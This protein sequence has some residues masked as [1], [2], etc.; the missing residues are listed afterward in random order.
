MSKGRIHHCHF[1]SST[2]P[3][4]TAVRLQQLCPR[5]LWSNGW[6]RIQPIPRLSFNVPCFLGYYIAVNRSPFHTSDYYTL[7]T[8]SMSLPTPSTI[9]P[10]LLFT[11]GHCLLQGII[12]CHMVSFH[13][14]Q[15]RDSIRLKVFIYTLFLLCL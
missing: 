14:Q 9:Q 11:L 2:S 3:L 10:V 6:F 1:Q 15:A 12:F 5:H 4:E 13:Q 7:V 8:I